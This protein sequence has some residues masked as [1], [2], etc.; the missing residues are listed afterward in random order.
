M[1]DRPEDLVEDASRL[2]AVFGRWPTFHD[3]EVHR[4]VLDRGG[5]DGPSLEAVIHVFEMTKEVNAD[6]FYVLKNHTLVTLRFSNV[7]LDYIDDFNHQNV[8]YE[9]HLTSIEPESPGGRT[10][11]VRMETSF[12]LDA[13]FECASCK[14]MDLQPYEPPGKGSTR[15]GPRPGW[16]KDV[17]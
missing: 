16:P 3:A 12:G 1:A 14:V 6:G 2:T 11:A 5:E 8:I 9:L 4:V 13:E 10:I 15:G 7:A 17:D